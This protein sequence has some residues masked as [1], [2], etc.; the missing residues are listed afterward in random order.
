MSIE[1]VNSLKKYDLEN[2]VI[3]TNMNLI[4]LMMQTIVQKKYLIKQ[5][6][7]QTHQALEI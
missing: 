6:Q 2:L 1:A 5:V 7:L 4:V 3:S